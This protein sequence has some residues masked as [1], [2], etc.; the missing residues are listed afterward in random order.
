MLRSEW[1]TVVWVSEHEC[2]L[3]P[4]S[5]GRPQAG[6]AHL[7]SPLTSNV[8]VRMPVR[9][10]LLGLLLSLSAAAEA[11]SDSCPDDLRQVRY[12]FHQ[13]SVPNAIQYQVDFSSTGDGVLQNSSGSVTAS[14][15]PNTMR[16][17][18]AFL[19]RNYVFEH[20]WKR[21]GPEQCPPLP[22]GSSTER[23]ILSKSDGVTIEISSQDRLWGDS[24]PLRSLVLAE[25][26]AHFRGELSQSGNRAP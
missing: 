8:R 15:D 5:R 22:P 2:C 19:C 20:Q 26:R 6:F 23:L 21:C 11:N 17:F 3:T 18:A 1:L 25:F 12:I 7:R 13:G 24:E 16:S 9:I 14:I 4:P 10:L